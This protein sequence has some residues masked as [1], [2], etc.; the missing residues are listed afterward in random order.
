MC[1]NVT[2]VSAR[3]EAIITWWYW[4]RLRPVMQSSADLIAHQF[5]YH[6]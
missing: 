1:D 4:R 3:V 5:D 2:A 6:R